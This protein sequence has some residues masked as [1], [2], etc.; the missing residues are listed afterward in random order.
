MKKIGVSLAVSFAACAALG[1]SA[2]AAQPHSSYWYPEQLLKWSPG[3]DPDAKFNRGSIPLQERFTGDKVNANA[4]KDPKIVALSALNAGTSG[5]PSQGS[6]KFAANTFGYWQY[7]DKLVYWGGSAGEGII[8]PP[9]ADAIDAAHKNGVPIMGTVFFPPSVYGGKYDWVKQTLQQKPDGSFPVADKLI[10]VAKTYGFDGWFINQ[11]TEGGTPADAQK[12]KEFLK[13]LEARKSPSMQIMWYDSMTKDGAISWQNALND[14]NEMFL[15]DKQ[16]KVSDSMFLNFWWRDLAGSAAKAKSLGRSPYELFAGIDVEAKG[17][18]TGIQWDMLFPQG[19][20]AATSL[21]IYR[22]DWAFNSAENMKDFF[23]RENKFWVGQNGDP[24]RTD[25]NQAWK[26]MAHYVA[27]QSPVNRLPFVTHFNTG[28]GQQYYVDGKLVRN[29]GW[30]NRSLQDILPTWRWMA[31]SKGTALKPSL[32]WTDAYY[33]GSSL[34][35]EGT[36]SPANATTLKLYRTDLAI[37]QATKLS[38][39][40]KT[41]Q[42]PGMKVALT[43]ADPKDETVYLDVKDKVQPGWTTETFNLTPYKGK[44]ISSISLVFDSKETIPAYAINIG[45]LSVSSVKQEQSWSL[46]AV[47]D[48]KVTGSDFRDGI[49]GDARL[50]W[51]ALDQ[52]VKQYEIYRVLPDGKEEFLGATPNNVYYVPEM[53]RSNKEDTTVLKVVAVNGQYRAGQAAAAAIKWPAYPKPAARFKTDKTLVAP[54]E[55]VT[56]I[57]QSTEVTEEW[58]WTIDGASPSTST[59]KQPV[60]T[61]AEEGVYSVTL[62]AKNSAG[63]D[64]VTKQAL[65]TVRKDAGAAVNLALGKTAKADNACGPAEGAA[66]AVDGKVT[67]N[68]KWCALGNLPH[69]LTVDLGAEK[70]ISGFVLKHA[71]AGG[72]WAGFNTSDYT[73]QVSA[74]GVTW[75]DVLEVK[76]NRAGETNDAVAL[77]KARYVKLN[78]VKASQGGDTAARIYEFEVRGLQ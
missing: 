15:Q 62:T 20:P 38:V 65:I 69:W 13:Y 35:V 76:G 78:I 31:E 40:Y 14:K 58:L 4:S 26:G 30:N 8:V 36:L 56:L 49:Y 21:G 77:V 70:T 60:V 57:D 33:G 9:S 64:S 66:N 2:S 7:V 22:P 54:G 39:T 12:M 19:K 17:Y 73:V 53:K 63:Q 47:K 11:E 24:S 5:V 3:A 55:Q 32:D 1:L 45:K 72:E 51:T 68:S 37:E 6:D 23:A 42:K 16:Q 28:S 43:F 75:T 44:R 25:T 52:D 10:E 67:G 18:D 34:K 41:S 74:D 29:K 27:E 71:E 50:E 46:P 48:L 59:D 61:F